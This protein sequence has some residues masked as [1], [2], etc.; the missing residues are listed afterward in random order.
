MRRLVVHSPYHEQL[1]NYKTNSFFYPKV[2]ISLLSIIKNGLIWASFFKAESP[3][4]QFYKTFYGC[5]LL[6]FVISFGVFSLQ[7]FSA[8]SNKHSSLV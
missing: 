3:V 4:E 6:M 8:W 7:V 5:N 2:L 1:G